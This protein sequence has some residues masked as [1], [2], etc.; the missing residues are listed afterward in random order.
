MHWFKTKISIVRSL[1]CSN[2]LSQLQNPWKDGRIAW[3][4]TFSASSQCIDSKNWLVPI[5]MKTSGLKHDGDSDCF[6]MLYAS[7]K[8]NDQHDSPSIIQRRISVAEAEVAATHLASSTPHCFCQALQSY[9]CFCHTKI[10]WT[11]VHALPEI[12]KLANNH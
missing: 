7:Y 12:R 5:P 1:P 6:L 8:G 4:C 3:L 10:W 9:L 11:D 2:R